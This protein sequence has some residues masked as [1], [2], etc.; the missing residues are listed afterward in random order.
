M[1]QQI[2]GQLKYAQEHSEIMDLYIE[3]GAARAGKL[4]NRGPIAFDQSGKLSKH[5][6]DAC[7]LLLIR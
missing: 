6:L 5:I 2:G 3:N 7:T 1:G 4:G